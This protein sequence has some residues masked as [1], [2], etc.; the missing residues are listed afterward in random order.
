MDSSLHGLLLRFGWPGWLWGLA[1]A[2][3]LAIGWWAL[4]R[5]GWALGRLE[6]GALIAGGLLLAPYAASNSVLTV[7]AIGIV[8]LFQRAP[9]LGLA[10]IVLYDLPLISGGNV[11]LRLMWEA[12][13]WTGVLLLSWLALLGHRKWKQGDQGSGGIEP[14]VI[15]PP[16][17]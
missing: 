15:R 17:E 6:A 2:G 5:R 3:I 10:L 9:L 14:A 7:L 8:P 4:Q 16:G 13:Y 1:A 11:E 12:T